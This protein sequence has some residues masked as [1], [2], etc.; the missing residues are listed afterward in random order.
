MT[1]EETPI[2]DGIEKPTTIYS[3]VNSE[4]PEVA[5]NRKWWQKLLNP[6]FRRWAYGV[7]AAALV[8]GATWAG[9]PEFIPVAAPLIMAIFYVDK[10]GNPNG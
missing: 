9:K 10:N 6:T 1:N 2:Y 5:D 4:S 8:A 3:K 7:A